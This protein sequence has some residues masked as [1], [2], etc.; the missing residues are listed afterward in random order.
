MKLYAAVL[1]A[2]RSVGFQTQSRALAW[3]VTARN[4][5]EAQGLAI[6]ASKKA[7]PPEDGWMEHQAHV[8]EISPDA[9]RQVHNSLA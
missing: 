1:F 9:I 5:Y 7:F 3:W 8:S 6:E 2:N 4:Q